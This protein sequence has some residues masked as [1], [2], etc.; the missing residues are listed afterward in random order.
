MLTCCALGAENRLN[1]LFLTADSD[2]PGNRAATCA[3]FPRPPPLPI[4]PST[5]RECASKRILSSASDQVPTLRVGS[6]VGLQAACSRWGLTRFGRPP[7]RLRRYFGGVDGDK[8]TSPSLQLSH[9][10]VKLELEDSSR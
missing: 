8:R 10:E 5:I 6:V 1:H 2:L 9:D 3:H 7:L 4:G